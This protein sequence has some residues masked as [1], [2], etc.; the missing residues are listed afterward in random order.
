[1][2][3][4]SSFALSKKMI[5][6][7]KTQGYVSPTPIQDAV[8]PKALRGESLIARSPTGTGKTHAFLIPI[9]EKIEIEKKE[10]QAVVVAPTRELAKQTYDFAKRFS[11]SYPALRILLLS[12]G[13]ER[14]RTIEKLG[15]V[16][17]LIIA[18][19]GRLHDLAVEEKVINFLTAKT[20]VL[21]EADMLMEMGFFND[22]NVI[23]SNLVKPQVLVFSATI[24][25]KLASALEK[26]A[27][28]KHV[29][30]TSSKELTAGKVRHYFIDTRHQDLKQC[31]KEFI[32]IKHPYLLL[33]F[34][35]K[36][37]TVETVYDYL[38]SQGIRAAMIHGDL[39]VR[40]R[41]SIMRRIHANEFNVIVASDMASRGID[42]DDV[43]DVL[44]VDLPRNQEFYYHR[45][46]R[47][48]RNGKDGQCYSFYDN[49]LTA[50]VQKIL[51]MGTKVEF[52]VFRDGA[53]VEGKPITPATPNFRKKKNP[54]LEKEIKIAAGKASSKI[55]KP[56][57]KRKV[58]V[59]VERAKAR[60]RRKVIKRDIR[61]QQVERYK[62]EAKEPRK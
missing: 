55:V 20:F 30:E 2:S 48:G 51:D 38:R 19:P 13:E 8:I 43:S 62:S 60:H 47:T 21:D 59:A 6:A 57:Y 46:G 39:E 11:T 29:I 58:R 50:P 10:I 42:I 27:E 41:K 31:V 3:S 7:L 16:P 14:S 35:S 1:M 40:E 17:H 9:I 37:E 4:F 28:P 49:D 45:A 54:E 52:L 44:N 24:P 26:Y 33:I 12:A 61:R 36:K 34:A 32:E 56:G 5:D 22:I 15:R 53:L 23:I 25:E 18:T